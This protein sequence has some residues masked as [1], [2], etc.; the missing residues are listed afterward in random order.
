[1]ADCSVKTQREAGYTQ[2]KT[3]FPVAQGERKTSRG[4]PRGWNQS[5]VL[6]ASRSL[7]KGLTLG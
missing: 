1:M 3:R 4:N 7:R 6:G 5:F 2:G